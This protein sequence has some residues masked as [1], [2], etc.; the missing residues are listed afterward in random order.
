LHE[1]RRDYVAS[2][3]GPEIARIPERQDAEAEQWGNCQ[4][5]RGDRD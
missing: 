2:E 3:M 4:R 5:R 1:R